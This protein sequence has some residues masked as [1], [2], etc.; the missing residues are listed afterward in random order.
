MDPSIYNLLLKILAL[1]LPYL[2]GSIPSALII[3]RYFS[4]KD[5]GM[6]GSRNIGAMN[7]YEV[8]KKKHI[9]ILV[10][11]A[12]AA[13]GIAAVLIAKALSYDMSIA[14]AAV[15]AAVLGHNF[16][17]YLKFRG[18]RGLATALGGMLILSPAAPVLWIAMWLVGFFVI[19]KHVHV[20]N[21]TATVISPILLFYAPDFFI[22]NLIILD[23]YRLDEYRMAFAAIC[24]LIMLRHIVPL[25]ELL[26]AKE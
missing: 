14:L 23:F 13:K 8:T 5:L 6:E 21:I 10:L 18:G 22:Y 3:V 16:S 17:I 11:L 1:V 19:K 20:G 9:G 7:S 24:F 2:V 4:K 26:K 15:P 12:D 25:K